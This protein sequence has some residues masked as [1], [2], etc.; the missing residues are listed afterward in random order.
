[1]PLL[2]IP[3]FRTCCHEPPVQ[4]FPHLSTPPTPLPTQHNLLPF[5]PAPLP[6]DMNMLTFSL[7]IPLY[8]KEMGREKV[9]RFMGSWWPT[10][11]ARIMLRRQSVKL[12][13]CLLLLVIFLFLGI[14]FFNVG[15]SISSLCSYYVTSSLSSL[16]FISKFRQQRALFILKNLQESS[17]SSS[18]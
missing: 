17:S 5:P 6:P 16:S 4:A 7:P 10:A 1:M 3:S 15:V 12:L 18:Y 9:S 8:Y 13:L 14:V 11:H 2:T